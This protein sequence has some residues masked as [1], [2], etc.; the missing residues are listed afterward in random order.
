MVDGCGQGK[1]RALI[2]RLNKAGV[3]ILLVEQNADVAPM[4]ARHGD[5]LERNQENRNWR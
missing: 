1:G 4:L 5:V 3:T 2:Q